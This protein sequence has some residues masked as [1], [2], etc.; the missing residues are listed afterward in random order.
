MNKDDDVI[1]SRTPKN[2]KMNVRVKREMSAK[3]DKES[4][5]LI[6]SA[7]PRGGLR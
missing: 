5:S 3:S 4:S 1:T 6:D 7:G 2:T